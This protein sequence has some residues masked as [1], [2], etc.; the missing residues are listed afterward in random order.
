LREIVRFLA[1]MVKYLRL[2]SCDQRTR[3]KSRWSVSRWRI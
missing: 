2:W 3:K 1:E